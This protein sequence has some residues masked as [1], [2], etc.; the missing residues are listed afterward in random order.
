MNNEDVLNPDEDYRNENERMYYDS[1]D[2]QDTLENIVLELKDIVC[3]WLGHHNY[4]LTTLTPEHLTVLNLHCDRIEDQIRYFFEDLYKVLGA[5]NQYSYGLTVADYEENLFSQHEFELEL[6]QV[7]RKSFELSSGEIQGCYS[8]DT[9][10]FD[11]KYS[12]YKRELL[13]PVTVKPW[14]IPAPP[15]VVAPERP[16]VIL[17]VLSLSDSAPRV[18]AGFDDVFCI[19]PLVRELLVDDDV[20]VGDH[21]IVKTSGWS[22]FGSELNKPEYDGLA[23]PACPCSDIGEVLEAKYDFDLKYE[24]EKQK[25]NYRIN[26]LDKH[27]VLRTEN[28]IRQSGI[29]ALQR[30]ENPR[31]K[32][33]KYSYTSDNMEEFVTDNMEELVTYFEDQANEYA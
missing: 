11:K 6:I 19:E 25:A 17:K 28:E 32:K 20:Q 12:G 27:F 10:W 30:I 23:E 9:V 24:Q 14:D 3:L 7:I 33:V 8:I 16:S 21:I 29:S 18:S 4:K 5:Q 13:R 22:G 2:F 1:R 26:W 31:M 15:K